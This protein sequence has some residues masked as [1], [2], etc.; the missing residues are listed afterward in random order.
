M[1]LLNSF[2]LYAQVVF[3]AWAGDLDIFVLV[4]GEGSF[5]AAGRRL[6]VAPSSIARVIDRIEARLG[7]RR[8]LR[9]TR[10]LILTPEGMTYLSSARRIIA[11]LGLRGNE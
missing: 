7:V 10:S 1:N 9:T 4:A 11:D 3:M 2:A 8:L 6:K 5:S